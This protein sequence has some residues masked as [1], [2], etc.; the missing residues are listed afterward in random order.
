MDTNNPTLLE[1]YLHCEQLHIR[2]L[3]MFKGLNELDVDDGWMLVGRN[4]TPGIEQYLILAAGTRT[5]H[6]CPDSL[7]RSA[8]KLL[9][10]GIG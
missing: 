10:F 6:L 1:T 5:P 2:L 7:V 8:S 4:S 9:G 3:G